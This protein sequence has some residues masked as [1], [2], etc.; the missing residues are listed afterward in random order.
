MH[1]EDIQRAMTTVKHAFSVA[2]G[3]SNPSGND[4][5]SADVAN[6]IIRDYS[7]SSITLS[8]DVTLVQFI[9][10]V[11]TAAAS[12]PK[13][14]DTHVAPGYVQDIACAFHFPTVFTP[15]HIFDISP[16]LSYF[17]VLLFSLLPSTSS[18]LLAPPVLSTPA[19]S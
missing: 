2:T 3:I 17:T 16:F 5:I 8:H 4:V 11:F 6:K 12:A 14:H 9:A 18:P 1:R 7:K 19:P 15:S 13:E 10:T